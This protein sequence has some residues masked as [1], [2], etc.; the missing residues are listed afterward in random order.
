MRLIHN[1]ANHACTELRVYFRLAVKKP[2]SIKI[3][4]NTV[5]TKDMYIQS[6]VF[7]K[8]HVRAIDT[9]AGCHSIVLL[10]VLESKI[11]KR[12]VFFSSAVTAGV[13]Y[14][15]GLRSLV[16]RVGSRGAGRR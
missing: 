14:L 12:L 4:D 15:R 6:K 16:N 5:T 7:T 2:N 13:G 11:N 10:I 3:H 9:I 8:F 1:H